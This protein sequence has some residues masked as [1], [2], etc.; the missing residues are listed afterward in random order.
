VQN[1]APGT[2]YFLPWG[3]LGKPYFEL[4][5]SKA[6]ILQNELADMMTY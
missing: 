1:K 2:P 3:W 5:W 6:D 4:F